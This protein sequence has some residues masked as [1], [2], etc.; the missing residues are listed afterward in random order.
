MLH[1]PAHTQSHETKDGKAPCLTSGL[2]RERRIRAGR[3]RARQQPPLPRRPV[4]GACRSSRRPARGAPCAAGR[5]V[6]RLPARRRRRPCS[7]SVRLRGHRSGRRSSRCGE[8]VQEEFE[9]GRER[10]VCGAR[11]QRPMQ[12]RGAPARARQGRRGAR[13]R[14]RALGQA[15]KAVAGRRGSRRSR[16]RRRAA[17]RRRCVGCAG[18]GAVRG[19]AWRGRGRRAASWPGACQRR[20]AAGQCRRR[21]AVRVSSCSRGLCAA[22]WLRRPSLPRRG[23]LAAAGRAAWRWRVRRGCRVAAQPP[24]PRAAAGRRLSGRAL[25]VGSC[26]APRGGCR[27]GAV[28]RLGPRAQGRSRRGPRAGTRRAAHAGAAGR[29]ARARRRVRVVAGVCQGT[30]PY[31]VQLAPLSAAYRGRA[32]RQRLHSSCRARRRHPGSAVPR[33][34]L[35]SHPMPRQSVG[36]GRTPCTRG[37]RQGQRGAEGRRACSSLQGL[38]H[39][40]ARGDRL[41]SGDG[42]GLEAG[43]A[44]DVLHARGRDFAPRARAGAARRPARGRPS[45]PPGRRRVRHLGAA[46]LGARPAPPPSAPACLRAASV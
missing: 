28:R 30:R 20:G 15:R 43:I 42:G 4:T 17:R 10:D 44:R 37:A 5:G 6:E 19:A 12:R 34:A 35:H 16:L 27:G 24:L 31:P 32:R 8:Q 13:R 39:A 36:R 23:P 45:E 11:E 38:G 41:Q 25:P 26:R 46:R 9:L 1:Q 40:P 18:C 2:Q 33:S 3:R 7:V 14:A 29:G 22:W 21:C